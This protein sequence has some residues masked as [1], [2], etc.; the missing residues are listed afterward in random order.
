ML[1]ELRAMRAKIDEALAAVEALAPAL[2]VWQADQKPQELPLV[3]HGP[4][5]AP[6]SSTVLPLDEAAVAVAGAE[7]AARR[8][9]RR[10]ISRAYRVRRRTERQRQVEP[11]A[12]EPGSKLKPSRPC[13]RCGEPFEPAHPARKYCSDSCRYAAAEA[14]LVQPR[15]SGAWPAPIPAL[16]VRLAA[17]EAESETAAA[18]A[19]PVLRA[20]VTRVAAQIDQAKR[21]AMAASPS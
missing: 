19:L 10:Q 5:G 6:A 12:P 17:L 20:E 15:P 7:L 21:S 11:V 16:Q 1:A 14:R 18:E 3:S 4:E 2:A 9:R 13:E 8:E